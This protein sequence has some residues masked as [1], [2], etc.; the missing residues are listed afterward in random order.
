MAL[1]LSQWAD[2]A[3]EWVVRSGGRAARSDNREQSNPPEFFYMCPACG[4]RRER[5]PL[6]ERFCQECVG[7]GRTRDRHVSVQTKPVSDEPPP[8]E[9]AKVVLSL[10]RRWLHN[11]VPD[12]SSNLHTLLSQQDGIRDLMLPFWKELTDA[13]RKQL[14]DELLD[15]GFP[16][17][18]T[19]EMLS[20]W[21]TAR[22]RIRLT[23]QVRTAMWGPRTQ[24]VRGGLPGLGKRG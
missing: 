20:S 22:L 15:Q 4:F 16:G 11:R 8:A 13:Q 3:W 23:E 18:K 21:A 17:V 9:P 5:P 12:H 1:N 2:D 24:F 6:G 10:A 19:F 14:K 7:Q